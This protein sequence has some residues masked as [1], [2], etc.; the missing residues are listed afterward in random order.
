MIELEGKRMSE[1]RIASEI[2]R[3]KREEQT[4]P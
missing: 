3:K 1:E 2:R 4:I